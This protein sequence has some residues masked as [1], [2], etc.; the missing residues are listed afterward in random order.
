MWYSSQRHVANDEKV[1]ARARNSRTSIRLKNETEKQS[2]IKTEIWSL[3]TFWVFEQ[4]NKR[5][6]LGLLEG[7]S[8][9]SLFSKRVS[10]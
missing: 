3:I 7:H 2:I 5:S 8:A 1:C 4:V 9:W 6:A 10:K